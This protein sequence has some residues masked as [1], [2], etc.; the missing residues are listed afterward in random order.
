[1][2]MQDALFTKIRETMDNPKELAK[3]MQELLNISSDAAYRRLRG[4][5]A[6]SI[7]EAYK[8]GYNYKISLSDLENFRNDHVTFIR[9]PFI[10]NVESF[11]YF[12]MQSLEQLQALTKDPDHLMLYTAKD[13]PVFYQYKYREL[14][15]F[16]IYVWMRSIY[17][18]D[19]INGAYYSLSDIPERLLELAQ[20]QWEAYSKINSLEIWNDTTLS[21]LIN[22]IQYF[23]EAGMLNGK[24]EALLLCDQIQDMLKVIY[25]QAIHGQR[26][27]ENGDPTHISSKLY[28]NEVLIMDNNILSRIKGRLIYNIPYA[29][30]NFLSTGNEELAGDMYDYILRQAHKSSYMTDVSEKDR[31]RFFL[32]LRNKVDALRTRIENNSPFE[33]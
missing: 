10:N 6:L 28:Y 27:D 29:A 17:D 18:I 11:E 30:V 31:N 7:D 3:D 9:R 21:S 4:E 26:V 23:Y 13:V 33:F 20:Q 25:K 32:R 1:M 16:K 19:K 2:K 5:T 22:Q 14:G 24:E 15:A 8:L 12:M